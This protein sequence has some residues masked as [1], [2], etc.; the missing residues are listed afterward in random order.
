MKILFNNIGKTTNYIQNIELLYSDYNLF[1]KKHFSNLNLE[2]LQKVYPSSK[3]FL[4]H[5]ATGGLEMIALLMNIQKGDEIIMPSFTFVS[6]ANAFASRGATPVFI[7]IDKEA[8]NL[9][10][11]LVE[12]AI[13]PKTKAIV[14]VHYAGHSCDLNRLKKICEKHNLFLVEDAA[15][16]FG[17]TYNGLPLGTIGDFGVISFDVTKQVSAIQGGLL[18]INN[19][20][21]EKRAGYIYH[22]G[23][24]RTDFMEGNI[25]YYEWVDVGSKFQMNEMNAVALYDQLIQFKAILVHRNQLSK[26][27]YEQLKEL[28]DQEK[29]KLMPLQYL[30]ENYHEFYILL[31]DKSERESLSSHLLTIGI[32]T[33]FHYIPLHNS[34]KGKSF[35][36]TDLPNSVAISDS[37][38][39]LPLHTEMGNEEVTF[40]V[41]QLKIYFNDRK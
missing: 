41:K 40:I 32:E 18:L 1:R 2:I 28:E 19:P 13:T 33:M 21:F 27:Y 5:S 35:G 6:T 7:D 36:E 25:P 37:L 23:T 3:L 11:E 8:L 31:K 17:N 15:M 24:N 20:D 12:K 29:I 14:A 16:A 38:L 39:R 26:L 10:L 4:T 34:K 22:I 30:E 9:D